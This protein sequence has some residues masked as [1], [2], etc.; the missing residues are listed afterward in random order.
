MARTLIIIGLTTIAI[1]RHLN[2]EVI[3]LAWYGW[4]VNHFGYN[5]SY[6]SILYSIDKSISIYTHPTTYIPTLFNQK[7]KR[8]TSSLEINR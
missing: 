2:H 3:I 7:E 8:L 1:N 6:E 5:F 4:H